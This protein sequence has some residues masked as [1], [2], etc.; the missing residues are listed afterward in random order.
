[1]HHNTQEGFMVWFSNGGPSL[2]PFHK[3][4]LSTTSEVFIRKVLMQYIWINKDK[5]GV[6]S[7]GAVNGF[8]EELKSHMLTFCLWKN[9]FKFTYNRKIVSKKTFQACFFNKQ[10]PKFHNFSQKK[11]VLVKFCSHRLMK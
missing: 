4:Q 8:Y 5:G 10:I 6:P 9:Y 1:M 11:T 3:T 2:E 7:G